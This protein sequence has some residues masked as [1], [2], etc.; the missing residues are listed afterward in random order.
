VLVWLSIAGTFIT[1]LFQVVSII[2]P[3]VLGRRAATIWFV[4]G[5]VC[6]LVIYSIVQAL[7]DAPP[8]LAAMVME[9]STPLGWRFVAF[10][11]GMMLLGDRQR[12]NELARVNEQLLAAQTLLADRAR[13]AERLEISRE[14]HDS[15]GHHLVAMNVQ[16]ELARHQT[17][18]ATRDIVVHAQT[19]GRRMLGEVRTIVSTWRTEA[20]EVATALRQLASELQSPAI[21]VDIEDGLD[22]TD[23]AMARA[24][25]RCAQEVVTNAIRHANAQHVWLELTASDGGVRLIGR[26]DG[27]GRET[28]TMGNGLRGLGERAEGLRGHVHVTSTPGAGFVVTMWL[29]AKER[30]E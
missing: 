28:I 8:P 15:I 4:V 7:S 17:E 13:M 14:L 18:G 27:C 11:V 3:L 6:T 22:V 20:L 25:I 29:P 23:P 9:V 21:V 1:D 16:L 12:R 5:N 26:D 24:L 30:D 2:L 10:A 19:A